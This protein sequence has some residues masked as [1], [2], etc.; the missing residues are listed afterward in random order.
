MF[1][2]LRK[3]D[4]ASY[5]DDNTSNVEANNT[6]EVITILEN[7]SIQLFKCFSDN[8]MEANKDK[9]HPAISINE[10]VSIK[11]DN[12]EIENA[13]SEKLLGIIID[14][15]LN[16]KEHLQGIMKKASQ[17]VNV[18]FRITSYMNLAKRKLLINLL[19]I[20]QFNYYPIV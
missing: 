11:I 17:K 3:T 9:S 8:Q 18:L 14:S 10:K 4:F 15:K 2:E 20:S 7:D 13:L 19:F 12:I 1:F 6:N 16:F 5:D